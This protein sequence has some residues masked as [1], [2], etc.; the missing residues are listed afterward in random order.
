LAV[1]ARRSRERFNE[2][3]NRHAKTVYRV[4]FTLMKN[5]SDTDDAVSETFVR[6]IQTNPTLENPE[7]EKAWLIRVAGNVCKDMLRHSSRR[8]LDLQDFSEHL[9]TGGE[10]ETDDVMQAVLSLPDKYKTA[11]YLFY[12]EGY[13]CPE[14]AKITGKPQ[15]TVRYHLQVARKI[16]KQKLGDEFFCS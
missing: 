15:P 8:N 2:I 10:F 13:S 6:L 16:L 5:P 7:H 11:V 1:L 12:F 4:C 14:I 9:S 3:Y